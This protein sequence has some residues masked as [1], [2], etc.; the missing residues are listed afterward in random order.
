MPVDTTVRI[1]V[2][3]ITTAED[4]LMVAE[5]GADYVGVIVGIDESPR[6]VTLS[7]A[8]TIREQSLLPVVLLFRDKKEE[9]IEEAVALLAPHAV[10]L[11]GEE[12]TVLAARLA[13]R[14]PCE[15][16]KA[17]HLPPEGVGRSEVSRQIRNA[18]SMEEAGVSAILVDTVV[19]EGETRRYGGT[20]QVSDWRLARRVVDAVAVPAFLAGGINPENVGEAIRA[21]RPFGIDLASGVEVSVGQKDPEKVRRLVQ[22]VREA[23]PAEG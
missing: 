10:Q 22:A 15:I 8:R 5:A 13:G 18:L 11:Q 12:Y 7:Q 20:G 3:G 19:S 14:L 21:V 2:C 6:R 9:Q 16:W 23:S 1:K 4:A 17:V